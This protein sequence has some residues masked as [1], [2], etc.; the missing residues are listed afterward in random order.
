MANFV[1]RIVSG[2]KARF[3]DKHLDLELDLVYVTDQI[4]IMGFPATGVEGIFRN[5][6]ED[7]KKFL[8]YRHGKNYWVF[9]FCPLRENS[10]PASFF[11]GRVSRYPFPDHHAPP[12]AILPLFVREAREWLS[13]SPDRV[14]VL[15]CKAGKGRSG[16]LACA[17]LLSLD[18]T[19][20]PPKL[21]RS[22]TKKEWAKHRADQIMEVVDTEDM[23]EEARA[24]EETRVTEEKEDFSS[25]EESNTTR[26]TS[27]VHLEL[28]QTAAA[29]FE[30]PSDVAPTI[31]E[32]ESETTVLN[33]SRS[34]SAEVHHSA[35]IA[36]EN[37]K[38]NIKPFALDDVLALHTAR[39]MKSPSSPEEKLKHGV[40][41]PSQR[42]W[43]YYWSLLLMNSA[44]RDFWQTPL[45][46]VRLREMRVRVRD[47][48]G[49]KMNF[50]KVANRVIEKTNAAKYGV[51]Q[52][53]RGPVWVSLAR[54]NDSFVEMLERWERLTR[55]ED[56][57]FALRRKDSDY[58]S[59]DGALREIFADGKWDKGKMIRSFTRLGHRNGAPD[60]QQTEAR[61]FCLSFD[62]SI[63]RHTLLPLTEQ[64][65]EA[66]QEEM[67][68]HDTNPRSEE[69][70]E[71]LSSRKSNAP[72]SG[73]S[74]VSS[75][76][77]LAHVNDNVS[78]EK[79]VILDATRELRAKIYMGQVFMGWFWFIPAFH[80]P[81]APQSSTATAEQPPGSNITHFVVTRKEV[82]FPIAAGAALVDVD[83]S[84]E[85]IVP[86][87]DSEVDRRG[88]PKTQTS[89]D[90]AKGEGGE[91]GS[92][93]LAGIQ[94][95]VSDASGRG[96][97][98]TLEA[99][100]Q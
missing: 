52:R 11:D 89:E 22:M 16:T 5:R 54:Y 68:E 21:Q 18:G 24:I 76:T 74:T 38:M 62:G 75:V 27:S 46:R 83:V 40:S 99:S 77:E 86:G 91:P 61:C 78:A 37:K 71:Y 57:N 30:G 1:R 55:S 95:A 32:P 6:R 45:P 2:N 65:W 7:A 43:L 69:T 25:Q 81:S 26:Q 88:P 93:L 80:M 13:G 100:D 49:V 17:Y 10:Y 23:D 67:R 72:D 87:A 50:L 63:V 58:M 31:R 53:G 39:R 64:K 41:I 92:G 36:D 82:D 44:P 47:L 59:E 51:Q 66:L 34:P 42:R 15:H 48:G 35:D 4:I 20:S 9:N 8:D 73:Q 19:P 79:G 94:A 96:A 84:L 33:P 70:H 12:L 56:G 90:S 98:E 85:W 14:A 97:V 29:K 60:R 3:K 28:E